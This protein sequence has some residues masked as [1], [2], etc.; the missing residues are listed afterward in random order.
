M[1]KY[2]TDDELDDYIDP[3]DYEDYDSYLNKFDDDFGEGFVDDQLTELLDNYDDAH[4]I[5]SEG[6]PFVDI[7][8]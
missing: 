3:L 5:I 2:L 4:G 1:P 6:D 7:K 8:F